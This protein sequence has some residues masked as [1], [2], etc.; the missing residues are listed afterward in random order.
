MRKNNWH[1][2]MKVLELKYVKDGVVVWEKRN[3]LNTFH[4]GGEQKILEYVFAGGSV[5]DNF[6]IG[7]D[8]R[9]SL[10]ESDTLNSLIGEPTGGGYVR[11]AVSSES[12]TVEQVNGIFQASSPVVTFSASS[13]G[14]LGPVNNIF[15]ADST[16]GTGTLFASVDMDQAVSL[17]DWVTV[18]MRFGMALRDAP[19]TDA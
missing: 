5:P 14:S 13:G 18:L 16:G 11:Q 2:L 8:D 12:F 6:Y 4:Y 7:L 1:G 10:S 3:L 19:L 17:A 15:L 9:T